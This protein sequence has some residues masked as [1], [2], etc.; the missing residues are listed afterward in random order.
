MLCDIYLLGGSP[1]LC[2]HCRAI[3]EELRRDCS[4]RADAAQGTELASSTSFVHCERELFQI[5]SSD[6]SEESSAPAEGSGTHW[7][8]TSA[9]RTWVTLKLSTAQLVSDLWVQTL[10]ASRAKPS[11][12]KAGSLVASRGL[13]P[14]KRNT[15]AHSKADFAFTLS[16]YPTDLQAWGSKNILN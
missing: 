10:S 3:S 2:C 4:N 7:I 13:S 6:V 15:R 5:H 16:S 11:L 1:E 9:S 12:G 8:A 14:A